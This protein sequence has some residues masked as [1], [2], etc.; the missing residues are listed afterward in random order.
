MLRAPMLAGIFALLS[1]GL[2]GPARA[3]GILHELKVGVLKHDMDN[4]WSG[5]K[6]EH[7]WDL[8]VDAIF[9][10][11]LPHIGGTVRPHAGF[12]LNNQGDTNMVFAGAVL[13]W[14]LGAGFFVSAGIGAALHDGETETR[15]SDKKELGSR[16]LF[17]IPFEAGYAI[18][19]KHRVSAYFAHVSN[20][21]LAS[22]N[23]GMDQLGLRYGYKF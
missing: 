22:P 6:R 5:F 11:S 13:E 21:F 14:N 23:E 15:Q 3:D 4:L 12:T 7:G 16:I 20:G 8:H 17:H 18:T 10:P 9:S 1:A 19:D 2:V